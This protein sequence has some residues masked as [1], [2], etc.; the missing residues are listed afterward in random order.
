MVN[1]RNPSTHLR[2]I[3]TKKVML[4]HEALETTMKLE[5]SPIGDGGGMEQVQKQLVSLTI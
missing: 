1:Y 5:A 3:D 2:A 4:Q